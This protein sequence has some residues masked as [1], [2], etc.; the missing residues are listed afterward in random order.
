MRISAIVL[1]IFSLLVGGCTTHTWDV[2][3]YDLK[4]EKI[5]EGR[6]VTEPGGELQT[7]DGRKVRIINATVIME[8][9]K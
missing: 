2:K 3:A 1:V 6:L 5:Y 4:G 8:E 7:E 9:V